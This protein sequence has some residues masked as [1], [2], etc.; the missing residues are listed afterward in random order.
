MTMLSINAFKQLFQIVSWW[1]LTGCF[2]HIFSQPSV[3]ERKLSIQSAQQVNSDED[4]RR[5]GTPD[6]DILMYHVSKAW[7]IKSEMKWLEF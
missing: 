5:S 4:D 2:N 6:Q 7:F 3:P 1:K